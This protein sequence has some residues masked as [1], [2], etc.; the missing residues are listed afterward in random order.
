M[1]NIC[2]IWVKVVEYGLY[3]NQAVITVLEKSWFESVQNIMFF[4]CFLENVMFMI[5]HFYI[6]NQ[7][8]I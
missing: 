1:V 6:F 3:G 4:V 7:K 8:E 2:T 5:K